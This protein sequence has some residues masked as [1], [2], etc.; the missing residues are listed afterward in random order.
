MSTIADT[1]VSSWVGQAIK[2]RREQLGL[3]LRGLA[4]QS[5]VSSSMISDIERGTKSPTIS[6]LA[7]LAQALGVPLATLV[8]ST[9]GS[10]GRIHVV[11]A[12]DRPEF[13][14]PTSG[15]RRNSFS[16]AFPGSKVEL[17]RY[18]VPPHRLAGPFAPH[19]SGTIEH[20]HVASGSIR[21]V[22]GTDVVELE[23]GDSCTC[24]ADVSHHFDN[25][26]G[27]VEAM[28]YIV[29]ERP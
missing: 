8:S 1:D 5:G 27:E 21:C 14:D 9:T 19:G 25:R 15:A 16:A 22:F 28:I 10:A 7:A 2:T 17:L 20:M 4:Q 29:V 11:R 3:T 23:A 13:V 6:T 26:N 12:A 18:V 24:F